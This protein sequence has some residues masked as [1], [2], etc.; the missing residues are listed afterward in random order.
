MAKS[1]ARQLRN[2]LK[3]IHPDMLHDQEACRLVNEKSFQYLMQYFDVLEQPASMMPEIAS[4]LHFYVRQ[5]GGQIREL[6]FCLERPTG[7]LTGEARRNLAKS[8]IRRLSLALGIDDEDDA[9]ENGGAEDDI[10]IEIRHVLSEFLVLSKRRKAEHER[11]LRECKQLEQ[12]V[13]DLLD[14]R[15]YVSMAMPQV[16][17]LPALKKMAAWHNELREAGIAGHYVTIGAKYSWKGEDNLEFPQDFALG[18]AVALI[19]DKPA[20]QKVADDSDLWRIKDDLV[21]RLRKVHGIR[22]IGDYTF[23]SSR[24]MIKSIR[25]IE[26][27]SPYLMQ[28]DLKDISLLIGDAYQVTSHGSVV[29]PADFFCSDLVAF[30]RTS[31]DQARTLTKESD[32]K[33]ALVVAKQE[34]FRARTGADVRKNLFISVESFALALDRLLEVLEGHARH[35]VHGHVFYITEQFK[36]DDDGTISIRHDFSV[37]ELTAFLLPAPGAPPS[38]L[39]PAQE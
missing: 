6:R 13:K 8:C 15:I 21:A 36:V 14:I 16:A 20:S 9:P 18:A 12:T 39:C 17:A 1:K 37:N 5:D 31:L 11:L 3:L 19:R 23:M 24:N 35:S 2:I 25:D 33:D 34:E 27:C 38:A 10:H 7:F 4:T 22:W 26:K 30:L 29:I 32:A 28:L